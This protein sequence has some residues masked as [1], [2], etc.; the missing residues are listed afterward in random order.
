MSI[1]EKRSADKL[2]W[3][4]SHDEGNTFGK[5][6][7]VFRCKLRRLNFIWESLEAFEHKHGKTE[8]PVMKMNLATVYRMSCRNRR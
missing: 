6:V 5:V 3:T 7:D 8:P 2:G 4:K 1:F